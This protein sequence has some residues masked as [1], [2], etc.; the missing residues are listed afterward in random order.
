M[1]TIQLLKATVKYAALDPKDFGK[2]PRINVV[3]TLPSGEEAKLWGNP[4]DAI[5]QLKKGEQISL[6]YD[7]KNYKLASENLPATETTVP[8]TECHQRPHDFAARLGQ[9]SS[10]Y[11]Q[12]WQQATALLSRNLNQAPDSLPG[13]AQLIN[14]IA[15]TLFQA[16]A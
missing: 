8:Q 3:C 13:S 10:Q 2:G 4:D 15:E 12:C 16:T 9:A 6:I 11:E 5:A 1:P 7:G 14:K